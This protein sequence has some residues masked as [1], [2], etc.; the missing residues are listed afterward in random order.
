MI[1]Q[2]IKNFF[3]GLLCKERS[4]KKL[5]LSFCMGVYIAFSPFPG[6]H[7]LFVFIFSWLLLLN[8]PVVFA[9]SCLIN[10]PWTMM[11]VYIFDYVVGC[12]VCSSLFDSDMLMYNPSWMQW[13]NGHVTHYTSLSD[14]SLWSFL[15]G[16]NILGIGSALF[17]YPVMLYIFNK[18]STE[19]DS[20]PIKR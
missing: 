11:P 9:I 14:I 4:P 17:L 16:G 13:F 6:F 1:T 12:W 18:L 10:N 20:L 19:N 15:I 7:T 3:I 8:M 5:A 2:K